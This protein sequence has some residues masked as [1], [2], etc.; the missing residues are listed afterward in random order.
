MVVEST[1]HFVG[2]DDAESIVEFYEE[3][4]LFEDDENVKDSAVF[5][6]TSINF[7]LMQCAV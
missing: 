7:F 4:D 6:E 1:E 3:N 5:K 2:A